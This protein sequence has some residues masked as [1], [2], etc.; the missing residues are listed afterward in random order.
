MPRYNRAR[1]E[2][3][4]ARLVE[5]NRGPLTAEEVRA[6]FV[7]VLEFFV[8][9]YRNPAPEPGSSDDKLR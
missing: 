9:R 7:P 2:A 5:D 3:I 6:L 1:T 8:R 4:L